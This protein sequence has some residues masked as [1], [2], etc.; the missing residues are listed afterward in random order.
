[1]KRFKSICS[2]I[3]K[4]FNRFVQKGSDSPFFEYLTKY[5]ILTGMGFNLGLSIIILISLFK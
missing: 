3:N 4:W 5:F 1:M 2:A